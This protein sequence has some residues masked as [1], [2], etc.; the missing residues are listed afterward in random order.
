MSCLL[1]YP[2]VAVLRHRD[3]DLPAER[4]YTGLPLPSAGGQ[5]L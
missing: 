1:M 2:A 5:P 4:S 3:P